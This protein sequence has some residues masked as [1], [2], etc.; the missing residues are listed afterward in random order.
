MKNWRTQSSTYEELTVVKHTKLS[1]LFHFFSFCL[2][3]LGDEREELDEICRTCSLL[4]TSKQLL[5]HFFWFVPYLD[6]C[7][8]L[9]VWSHWLQPHYSSC[10]RIVS[11]HNRLFLTHI[12][13]FLAQLLQ[14]S[15]WL[16]LD[17]L[18]RN[19]GFQK[20]PYALGLIQYLFYIRNLLIFP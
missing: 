19:Q 12:V 7:M 4:T 10:C 3:C 13:L 8:T 14:F 9:C 5:K 16:K 1:L 11:W 20:W 17:R 2:L 6:Q 15:H 18:K